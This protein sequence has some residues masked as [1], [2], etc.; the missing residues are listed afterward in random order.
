[1]KKKIIKWSLGILALAITVFGILLVIIF[2]PSLTYANK[3][4]INNYTVFHNKPLDENLKSVLE[5]SNDL[6]KSSE[7][8][9]PNVKFE[10]CLNDGSIY[11]AIIQKILGPAFSYGFYNKVVLKSNIN[12]K[13]NYAELNDYHWNLTQLITHEE[14]HC[15]QFNKLGFWESNPMGKNPTWKWEGYPEYVSRQ[16]EGEKDLVKNIE[17]LIFCEKTDNNNWIQFPDSTGTVIPYYKNW[18]LMQYCIEIKKMTYIQ[19]LNDTTNEESINQEMMKWF[20]NGNKS[21][22]SIR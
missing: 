5:K 3:T 4:K 22:S 14:T 1:M 18:L 20:S 19:V 12:C 8:Y 2:N 16:G 9:D 15:L 10:V 6:L 7:L 21:T 13:E 17:R 11:P